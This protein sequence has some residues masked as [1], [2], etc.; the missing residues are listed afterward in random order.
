MVEEGT[1]GLNEDELVGTDD[2]IP[3]NTNEGVFLLTIVILSLRKGVSYGR[4]Q[5]FKDVATYKK[6]K[7]YH[8]KALIV[9]REG[10]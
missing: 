10:S 4:H 8:L 5:R 6:E 1:C 2:D 9:L 3:L 7:S